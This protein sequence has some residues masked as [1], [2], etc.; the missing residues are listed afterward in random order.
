[1]RF[2]SQSFWFANQLAEVYNLVMPGIFMV[3]SLLSTLRHGTAVAELW[4]V[5][6]R[7]GLP[8]RPKTVFWL[9]L[10]RQANLINHHQHPAALAQEWLTWP[11]NAQIL[12]L[13][14]AW[15]N[16][17]NN[18]QERMLRRRLRLRLAQGR[19]LRP[20]DA[21]LLPGLDAL[22]ITNRQTLT[23]FG[24][25]TLGLVEFPSPAPRQTWW[26]DGEYLHI[27]HEPDWTRL[28]QLETFLTPCAPLTY[29]LDA[30][31]LRKASQRG[32]VGKLIETLQTGLGVPIPSD[33]RAKILGQPSLRATRGLLLE[34]SDP[35]E[36]RQLRRSETLREYFGHVLSPCHVLV[37]EQNAPRLLKLL[38]RRGIHAFAPLPLPPVTGS[39]LDKRPRSH[40]SR[41]GLLE[42]LGESVPILEF[43]RQS[44]RQQM[45]F[46]M[47][48]TAPS[49][50]LS[51]VGYD[52]DRPELHRITPSLI[53]ERG[54]HTYIIAYSHT[55]RGQRTYRLDRMD[56]PGTVREKA[57]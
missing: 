47:L 18:R 49:A 32:D 28:W 51:L 43:I 2:P 17:P 5:F 36:L 3:F 12:H 19:S 41:A 7:I 48:Y 31:S 25:A 4:R 9:A 38:E 37:E 1:M 11:V 55:R 57:G 8:L 16:T 34:F 44:I 33:L 39:A 22:G 42:P 50:H 27:P 46:D 15:E 30:P 26:L 40:F 35:A 45:A 14:E 23:L 13:F 53:E 10:C 21:R 52:A 56:V 54:G 20:S 29:A 6:F 24:K